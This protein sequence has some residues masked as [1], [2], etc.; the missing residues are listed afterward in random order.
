MPK[1]KKRGDSWRCQVSA[2]KDPVTGK[3]KY[4]S[5][6]AS[7]K[8]EAEYQAS[9][10]LQGLKRDAPA[11]T[12]KDAL[13]DY[14]AG[15]S[16]IL[17]PDTLAEYRRLQRNAYGSLES[18][19]LSELSN[20]SLQSWVNEYSK[21]HAAK[22]VR[23]AAGLLT[24][25]LRASYPD[26]IPRL[27]LPV[28]QKPE[29]VIP[30]REQVAVLLAAAHG[31]TLEAPLLLA[32]AGGLRRSE[33]AALL[34]EDLDYKAN[35]VRITKAKVKGPDG[36]VVKQPKTPTSKRVITLPAHT[37]QRIRE[38]VRRQGAV[39]TMSPHTLSRSFAELTRKVGLPGIRFHDLR[40]Y[41]ASVLLAA[42][43]PNRYAAERMG[44]SGEAMLQQVYQHTMADVW[45]EINAKIDAAF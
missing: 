20:K 12:I 6:T 29:L 43:I 36:W 5:F 16:A 15:R 24:S 25:A 34:P 44:H 9:Q 4:K 21:D 1:A 17:A 32:S 41:H 19:R 8:K 11:M 14:L 28:R 30:T 33:I 27:Q 39:C 37:M 22:T 35:T 10:Y 40:H 23:N 42:G 38:I 26:F 31:S 3:Y 2:G 7:T 45:Q 18:L 13:S